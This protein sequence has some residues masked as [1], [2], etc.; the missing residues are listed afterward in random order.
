MQATE[1]IP[2]PKGETMICVLSDPIDLANYLDV[3]NLYKNNKSRS[4]CHIKW[5]DLSGVQ[6]TETL[7]LLGHGNVDRLET[8]TPTDLAY[9]LV[10]HGLAQVGEIKLLACESG[11][12][13]VSHMGRLNQQPYCQ[14]LAD[15][16][17]RLGGPPTVVIGYD[18]GTTVTDDRGE[19]Y[20]KDT[21]QRNYPNYKEFTTKFKSRYDALDQT[22]ELMKFRNSQ[23]ILSNA[24]Q[25][26]I[27]SAD[28]F[29]W[30]Y[31]NNRLYTKRDPIGATYGIPGQKI[32]HVL[33]NGRFVP[34]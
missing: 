21:P 32:G 24:E 2:P 28:I 12:L 20:A 9:A 1:G 34:A 10:T 17:V 15:E 5:A 8:Y 3:W 19:T 16:L 23:E 25:L 13:S 26:A 7:Y 18:G 11:R 27:A 4:V 29:Q 33:V 6:D 14:L 31:D 22:A 30:F